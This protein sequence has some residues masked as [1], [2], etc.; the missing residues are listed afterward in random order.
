MGYDEWDYWYVDKD[1]RDERVSFYI[2]TLPKGKKTL[3]YEIRPSVSG[4]YR[5][6]PT[7][8]QGMYDP[9]I[10]VFGSEDTVEVRD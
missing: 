5:T 8:V 7:V 3:E 2:D 1:V 9:S 10:C 4:T 6:L